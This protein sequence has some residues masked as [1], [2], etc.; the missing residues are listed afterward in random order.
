MGL[1]GE[2]GKDATKIVQTFADTFLA[3]PL[4]L[5]SHTKTS[6]AQLTPRQQ[7]FFSFK[8]KPLFFKMNCRKRVF[9]RTL[10]EDD[11][12]CR[13]KRP[14]FDLTWNVEAEHFQDT[15]IRFGKYLGMSLKQVCAMDPE[16]M[17]QLV[18]KTGLLD[19]ITRELACHFLYADT[20]WEDRD[21]TITTPGPFQNLKVTKI[22]T[23]ANG[24][25]FL[26][27]M[28][29][30]CLYLSEQQKRIIVYHL[31]IPYNIPTSQ[32]HLRDEACTFDKLPE[33]FASEFYR[34]PSEMELADVEM[35]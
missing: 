16:Y 21:F 10:S 30:K 28:Y 12:R 29:L 31:Q 17:K 4:L 20:N 32:L 23:M 19:N 25:D 15:T 18:E 22:R 1:L 5:C 11:L 35:E 27:K 26:W 6:Y 14:F 33:Q 34:Q 24:I 13:S 9:S 8:T 7:G 3:P 2:E